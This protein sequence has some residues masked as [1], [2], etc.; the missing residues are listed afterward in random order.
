MRLIV[1]TAF[2]ACLS[3][4]LAVLAGCTSEQNVDATDR[5]ING[6][7]VVV[8][9]AFD[10]TTYLP[11]LFDEYT[12]ETGV[13]VI[14]RN[15]ARSK[16]VDEVIAN[17]ISPPADV[18]W[19]PD[20]SSAMRAADDN[21]L[22]PLRSV[23][24]RDYVQQGFSDPDNYWISVSYDVAVI[25]YNADLVAA[26][27]VVDFTSLANPT[28]KDLLCLSSSKNAINT[29]VIAS[30]IT[31]L[32]TRPAEI[33]VRGWVA[34]LGKAVYATEADLLAAVAAGECG[35]AIVSSDVATRSMTAE[36]PVSVMV[37]EITPI[38]AEA[39][40]VARHARNPEGGEAIVQWLLGRDIQAR[41]GDA[42][43]S[44]PANWDAAPRD[45]VLAILKSRRGDSEGFH[46]V[47]DRY[48]SVR[49]AERAR[50]R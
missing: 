36:A 2:T 23:A 26:E 15:A 24:P 27:D 9:A 19:I 7:P 5:N 48:E 11:S 31:T 32:Q 10:D 21:A 16:L 41:H 42:T 13:P 12:K 20:L 50:Y 35:I 43:A 28:F 33:A 39:I 6:I 45:D 38:D 34:N 30:M 49:L 22:R 29:A 8:Y 3:A 25:A 4:A 1:R 37:P 18:L 47:T 40:G 14:V 17:K 44:L 46:V